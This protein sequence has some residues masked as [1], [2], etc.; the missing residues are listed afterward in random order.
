M[1]KAMLLSATAKVEGKPD[2]V[3]LFGLAY[4][5]ALNPEGWAD[6]DRL[7]QWIKTWVS[8][9]GVFST[10]SESGGDR[11]FIEATK[12]RD[13]AI[14]SNGISHKECEQ[15]LERLSDSYG[16]SG[17]ILDMT[18]GWV[19]RDAN[20]VFVVSGK[21]RVAGALCDRALSSSKTEK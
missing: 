3:I 19:L 11:A 21:N 15:L 7:P 9:S 2:E 12:K 17:A 10:C 20:G 4:V 6:D 18:N 1:N 5:E 8:G 16:L 14:S 13:A